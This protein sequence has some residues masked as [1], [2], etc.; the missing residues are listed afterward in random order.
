MSKI[1]QGLV[2]VFK[3]DWTGFGR[4]HQQQAATPASLT[5]TPKG[6]NTVIRISII[7][8]FA[9][10]N[11]FTQLATEPAVTVRLHKAVPSCRNTIEYEGEYEKECKGEY[12]G[13]YEGD[14]KG[15]YKEVTKIYGITE[16]TN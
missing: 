12:E 4:L 11:I 7:T 9:T 8:T 2:L 15:Q 14:C 1:E 13:E 5:S 16:L 6:N 10:T 3:F